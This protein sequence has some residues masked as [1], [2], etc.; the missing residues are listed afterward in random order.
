L[1]NKVLEL[2]WDVT[3]SNGTEELGEGIGMS[4]S[5]F[6]RWEMCRADLM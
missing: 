6:V 3:I 2:L 1:A 4:D 5:Y